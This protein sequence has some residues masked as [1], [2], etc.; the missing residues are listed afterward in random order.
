MKGERV[1]FVII[2][3]QFSSSAPFFEICE[4]SLADVEDDRNMNI[5]SQY[6]TLIFIIPSFKVNSLLNKRDDQVVKVEVIF[7]E[8][9]N[10]FRVSQ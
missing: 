10:S 9:E 6:L 7:E 3:I 2:V 1:V 5:I 4:I 8:K